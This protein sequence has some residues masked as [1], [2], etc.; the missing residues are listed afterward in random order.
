M[1]LRR[2]RGK[3]DI[4][5]IFRRI[6]TVL[7]IKRHPSRET[8]KFITGGSLLCLRIPPPPRRFCNKNGFSLVELIVVILIIAILAVAVFAGGSAAI[9]KAH[10]AKATSDLHNYQIAVEMTLNETPRVANIATETKKAQ[11]ESIMDAL[12]DNLA[13]DY[14]LTAVDGTL[15]GNITKDAPTTEDTNYIICQSDK[16]DAWGNPYFMIIDCGER[17]GSS[18]SEF[19]MTAVTAGPN[20]I[21]HLD[22]NIDTDDVFSLTGYADGDVISETYNMAE[23]APTSVG[24]T[25]QAVSF[26]DAE[27]APV[28]NGVTIVTVKNA[29]PV[30]EPVNQEPVNEPVNQEPANQEPEEN[31]NEPV[32]ESYTVSLYVNTYKV[33]EFTVEKGQSVTLPELD[34]QEMEAAGYMEDYFAGYAH[35][36]YDRTPRESSLSMSTAEFAVGSEF[37]PAANTILY[38]TFEQNGCFLAGTKVMMADRTEKNIEDIVVGDRVLSYNVLTGEY[39]ATTVFQTYEEEIHH[40]YYTITLADGSTINPTSNHM[41]LTTD[42]FKMIANTPACGQLQVGDFI[43][44]M[45]GPQEVVAIVEEENKK[46]LVYNINVRDDDEDKDDDTNDTYIANGM[47]VHNGNYGPSSDRHEPSPYAG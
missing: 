44:T 26:T 38:A 17:G 29:A 33:R 43:M 8:A 45:S 12:N 3:N 35:I 46:C 47:I 32:A 25:A 18:S 24:A 13:A 27:T 20:S 16:T 5:I 1:V 36:G 7:R 31:N 4:G 10:I 30:A 40:N 19:Y 41:F 2:C 15:T 42:G 11:L 9:R 39:Y 21:L 37:T 14:K 34:W 6:C 22:G 28:N 23:A